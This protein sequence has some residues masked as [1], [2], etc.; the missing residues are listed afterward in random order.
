MTQFSL[1]DR[2]QRISAAQRPLETSAAAFST[3]LGWMALAYRGETLLGLVFGH[4]SQRHAAAALRR[5]LGATDATIDFLGAEDHPDAIRD[6]IE[7]LQ[8][9]AGGER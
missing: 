2:P 4:A 7:Q 6:L 5:V 9:F 8:Q 3:E 1:R